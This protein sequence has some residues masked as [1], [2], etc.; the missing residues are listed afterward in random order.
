MRLTHLHIRD[1]AIIDAVEIELAPGLTVLT[2]ETGAG[3]SIL[4]DALQLALGGR[5][6]AEVIRHEAARAEITATFE[7]AGAP[8]SLLERLAE[9]SLDSE[10]ELLVRRVITR[11][12]KSRAY[13]NGQPVPVQLLR[14]I[15]ESLAEIH[16]QHE[17]QSLMR[18]AVQR[19]LLD[20]Y[21]GVNELA[22]TV[23]ACHRARVTHSA[24]LA[25]LETAARDRDARLDLLRHQV[26]ELEAL[27]LDGSELA[28]LTEERSR[29]VHRGRLAEAAQGARDRLFEAEGGNAHTEASRALQALRQVVAYDARLAELLPSLEEAVVRLADTA[30]ELDRYLDGLDADPA[31]QA[32]LEQ[33]LAAIESLARKHRIEP[34]ALSDKAREL[35][36]E[37][38]R[39][40]QLEQN[41]AAIQADLAT[42][43]RAWQEAASSLSAARQ[44]AARTLSTDITA[45]MQTLGMTGGR[46]EIALIDT[47]MVT[48]SELTRSGGRED[49]EFRVSANAGQPPRPIAKVASGGELSRL[50]LAVQVALA[51]RGS[52]AHPCR[53]FD[54]V[55]SGV[56]GAVAEIVGRELAALS[57]HAQ[58]LCV[59]H[60]PQVAALGRQHW[61]VSKL[62]DGR[63]T[64][65]QIVPLEG[66]A[67]IEEIARM[68]GGVSITQAARD[69]AREMLAGSAAPTRSRARRDAGNSSADNARR[70]RGRDR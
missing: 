26:Q 1:F 69:H 40:E 50:S 31:R 63:T 37:L 39:L 22:A 51:A 59:T 28:T 24:A 27:S 36:T 46:F 7:L 10:D 47:P 56:G 49:V 17:F 30:R 32:A 21:A 3:K 14:E 52:S 45:R 44:K 64:R 42:A 35:R 70:S 41:A 54:E 4:V 2:G 68:L 57:L 53:V 67:R 43:V 34:E 12:G 38:E 18:S 15:G 61:R 65:T 33:R 23:L 19:E 62:T 48:A 20:D 25:E 11:E 6:G 5:A 8:R 60:L 9:Q 29:L 55:D 16:G 13:L 66:D 58:V